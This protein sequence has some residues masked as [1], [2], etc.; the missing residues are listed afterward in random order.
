MKY[1]FF[2]SIFMALS[3]Q[4]ADI[5]ELVGLLDRNDTQTFHS[6]IQTLS[7][8]NTAREDNNKTILMYAVWV[9]NTEAVK[10][11][12]EKGADVNAQ[13]A[14]GATALHLAAWRGH[15]PIAVYLIE[16]GASANAMSKEGMTPLDIAMM[17]ENHEIGAAIE[18]AAPKL[19]PL[20]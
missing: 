5:L 15:T 9:G 6:R 10:Y 18:K 4:G 12:I 3:L 11:L 20:L 2:L 19:K 17:R 1:P 13:D 16:K 7:D 14:G 8:A